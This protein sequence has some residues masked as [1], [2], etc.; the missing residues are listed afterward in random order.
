MKRTV[1]I[2][3]GS[4]AALIVLLKIVE[5]RYFVFG[6]LTAEFF[7]GFIALLF[8]GLGVWVGWKLTRRTVIVRDPDFVPDASALASL[9]ISKRE[10]EVLELIAQGLSNREIAERLFLSPHTVKSHSSS[11][12]IK[13]GARRRTEAI[14]R[15]KELGVLE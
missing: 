3:G 15:A 9:G 2:Y 10:L 1:L 8:T 11:L 4:M 5:Y 14:K 13:L 6:D 7:V 12:F